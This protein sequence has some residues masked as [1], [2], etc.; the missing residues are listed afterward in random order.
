M[1]EH[2]PTA[3]Q[4]LADIEAILNFGIRQPG[5]PGER[6]A[7]DWGAQRF[8]G[9]GLQDVVLEPVEVQMWEYGGATLDVWPTGSPAHIHR[10]EGLA[11]PYTEACRDLERDLIPFDP[12]TARDQIVVEPLTFLELPQ[13]LLREGASFVFDPE[14]EFDTLVQT[15]PFGPLFNLVLDP[16]VEAGAAGY[17]GILT[18]VPWETSQ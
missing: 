13:A 9:L 8:T 5:H 17:V 3:E 7:E 4:M 2:V 16:A 11:L 1:M 14:G 18:G 15:L 6:Q 10:F 12:S